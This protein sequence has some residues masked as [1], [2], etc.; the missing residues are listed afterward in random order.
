MLIWP[1]GITVSPNNFVSKSFFPCSFPKISNFFCQFA[2]PSTSKNCG[3]M[4]GMI[5]HK[6]EFFKGEVISEGILNLVPSKLKYPKQVPNWFHCPNSKYLLRLPHLYLSEAIL[7]LQP[8]P[9]RLSGCPSHV[10]HTSQPVNIS[11]GSDKYTIHIFIRV[12]NW[13]TF[14]FGWKSQISWFTLP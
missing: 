13:S 7:E 2:T 10:I 1:P 12:Y 3:A 11:A 4:L 9:F 14:V 8:V 5:S 6:M